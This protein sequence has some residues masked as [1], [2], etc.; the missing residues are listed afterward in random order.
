MSEIRIQCPECG[1][2][3]V[4]TTFAGTQKMRCWD[5]CG[6]TGSRAYFT[7]QVPERDEADAK[8]ISRTFDVPGDRSDNDHCKSVNSALNLLIM[9]ALEEGLELDW[10]TLRLI[11]SADGSVITYLAVIKAYPRQPEVVFDEGG[12]AISTASGAKV[13]APNWNPAPR[14]AWHSAAPSNSHMQGLEMAG[15]A[16][17]RSDLPPPTIVRPDA[18]DLELARRSRLE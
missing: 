6:A 16:S 4:R 3:D 8:I 17:P 12:V 5:G 2:Y 1:N 11:T 18:A 13:V 7:P 15:Y 10:G 9:S 14:S